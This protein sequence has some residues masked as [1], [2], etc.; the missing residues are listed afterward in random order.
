MNWLFDWL[1]DELILIAGYYF[2]GWLLYWLAG[3]TYAA[4]FIY[5]YYE[6]SYLLQYDFKQCISIVKDDDGGVA[7]SRERKAQ[8]E[9]L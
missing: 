1:V 3:C 7:R 2:V 9:L 4:L 6:L 5:D 8:N